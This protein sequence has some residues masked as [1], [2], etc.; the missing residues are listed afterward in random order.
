MWNGWRAISNKWPPIQLKLIITLLASVFNVHTNGRFRMMIVAKSNCS[1]FHTHINIISSWQ[2][3]FVRII[4]ERR[5][6]LFTITATGHKL[7]FTFRS[8]NRFRSKMG[9]KIM[10][11]WNYSNW[12]CHL[13]LFRR[14][15]SIW[16]LLLQ[17]RS[18]FIA[19]N[20]GGMLD[21]IIE[22]NQWISNYDDGR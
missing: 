8:W 20:S 15:N 19:F 1:R 13:Q 14:R 2:I 6:N 4:L 22:N 10:S 17:Q 18:Q 3:Q 9:P 16:H 12:A 7:S 5:A 11:T 21:T